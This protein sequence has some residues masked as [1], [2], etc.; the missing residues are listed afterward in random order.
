MYKAVL[1]HPWFLRRI[2]AATWVSH[3]IQSSTP[4]TVRELDFRVRISPRFPS[5]WSLFAR[6][7]KSEWDRVNLPTLAAN[8][9]LGRGFIKV[10]RRGGIYSSS[11]IK[12]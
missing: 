1:T 6:S 11:P 4:Q 10:S 9:F 3:S 12:K 7:G 2:V 8:L 5:F